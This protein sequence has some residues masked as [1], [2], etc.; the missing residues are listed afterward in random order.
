MLEALDGIVIGRADRIGP[1]DPTPV[2]DGLLSRTHRDND[3]RDS[4]P[5][6]VPRRPGDAGTQK[7]GAFVP[8]V[9]SLMRGIIR[10][11]RGQTLWRWRTNQ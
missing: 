11:I 8:A 7:C 4:Q 5:G 9:Q 1:P 6:P 2:W 10:A 3:Q